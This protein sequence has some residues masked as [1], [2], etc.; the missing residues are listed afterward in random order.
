MILGV[1]RKRE[2]DPLSLALLEKVKRQTAANIIAGIM[3]THP[4][5]LGKF[6]E[7]PTKHAHLGF[8]AG[9]L[10]FRGALEIRDAY[11]QQ[12]A[13][14]SYQIN[15]RDVEAINHYC[16]FVLGQL[17]VPR[18]VFEGSKDTIDD[19]MAQAAVGTPKKAAQSTQLLISVGAPLGD[20]LNS[21]DDMSRRVAWLE[22]H[23]ADK[24]KK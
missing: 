4:K 6:A 8:T 20:Q 19:L 24:S 18:N 10:S 16:T 1:T 21:I 13:P 23:H 11:A 15:K 3:I 22:E 14:N 12:I 17:D 5:F 9:N 7:L 2:E